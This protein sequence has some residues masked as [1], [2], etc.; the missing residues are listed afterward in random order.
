MKLT[1]KYKTVTKYAT[2]LLMGVLCAYSVCAC[3]GAQ[4][5][6]PHNPQ[7]DNERPD[8]NQYEDPTDTE[9]NEHDNNHDINDN[10]WEQPDEN[11]PETPDEQNTPD[12]QWEQPD[13]DHQDAPDNQWEQGDQEQNDHWEQSDEDHQ[14]IPDEQND[15][16]NQ[17]HQGE[18]GKCD[19]GYVWVDNSIDPW[20]IDDGISVNNQCVACASLPSL[21]PYLQYSQQYC[22]GGDDLMGKHIIDQLGL[23]PSYECPIDDLSSCY[24]PPS[25]K[26][27]WE[28][29]PGTRKPLIINPKVNV[30][31][32]HKKINNTMLLR[33]KIRERKI[34]KR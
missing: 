27:C 2:N 22:P 1:Y 15:Q 34:N 5:I 29:N 8:N 9:Q 16:D 28:I 25:T 17:E 14:D 10:Q 12:N 32:N 4:H 30:V 23:C 13:E 19:P 7:S 20:V 21:V 11:H 18:P 6:T 3:G 26:I 31:P 33:N 24:L